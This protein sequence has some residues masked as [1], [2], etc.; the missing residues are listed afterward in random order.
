MTAK[1]LHHQHSTPKQRLPSCGGGRTLSPTKMRKRTLKRCC[2][3]SMQ[4]CRTYRGYSIIAKECPSVNT[5]PHSVCIIKSNPTG[6]LGNLNLRKISADRIQNLWEFLS[7]FFMPFSVLEIWLISITNYFFELFKNRQNILKNPFLFSFLFVV[8]P[9]FAHSV[10]SSARRGKKEE[11]Q[12]AI[13][14]C[15]FERIWSQAS[16]ENCWNYYSSSSKDLLI[17][18]FAICTWLLLLLSFPPLIIREQPSDLQFCRD[19]TFLGVKNVVRRL[20]D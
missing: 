1:G 10:R 11:E 14:I 7:S 5:V 4:A 18:S 9:F 17:M 3:L 2:G 15:V 16:R 12:F 13:Q 6:L 19:C 8:L 20:P